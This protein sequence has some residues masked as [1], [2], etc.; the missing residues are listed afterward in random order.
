MRPLLP[1]AAVAVV[2]TLLLAALQTL[3]GAWLA[4]AFLP[5]RNA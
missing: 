1:Y 3:A 5:R 2:V 4:R